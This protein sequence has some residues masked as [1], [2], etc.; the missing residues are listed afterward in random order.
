MASHLGYVYVAPAIFED[1]VAWSLVPEEEGVG[2][3]AESSVVT[4][5]NGEQV[6]VYD[7]PG[8]TTML[9]DYYNDGMG[10][11]YQEGVGEYYAESISDYYSEDQQEAT[12]MNDEFQAFKF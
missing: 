1:G 7:L 11:Y 12:A 9:N 3:L 2:G 4:L 5:P 8:G 10:E 6:T